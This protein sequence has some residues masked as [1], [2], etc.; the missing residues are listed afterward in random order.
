MSTVADRLHDELHDIWRAPP[1]IGQLSAVNHTAVGTRYI[2]TG[3]V[4]FAVAGLLAMVMRAQLAWAERASVDYATYNELFTMHGTTMMF[5]FA[6]PMV[7]GLAVYL[8]PKM[9]GARDL[10]FPRL[11]AFTYWCYAFGGLLLYSSFVFDAVPDGGWFM[12]VPLNSKPYAPGINADFWLLGIT[13]VEISAV[14]AAI[15]LIVAILKTRAPGMSIDRMPILAWVMLVTAFMI[16][17]GFPPLILGGI[18]LEIERAF[19]IPFYDPA[20][21]GDPL[22][23]QHFFWIFGHPEVYIIFL[24]ATGIVSMVLPT[25]ARAP[26]AGYTWIVLAVI[27]TGFI[28]FGLWVHHMFAVGIPLLALSFFSAASMAV[29][30]PSGIQVFAWITTLWRGR[31]VRSVPLLYI[32]GFL[33]IFVLGGLTGVMVALVPFDW[34]VHD[35]HFVVAHFHY[36]LIGGVVFPLLA[37]IYYWLPL[38]SGRKMLPVL[39]RWA[40]WLLFIGFNVTFLP[41]HLTGLIGMPRRVYTYP[42][43]LGWEHLNALDRRRLHPHRRLRGLPD[44]RDP[45]PAPRRAHGHESLEC[46]EPRVEPA[47]ARADLHLREPPRVASRDPLWDEPRLPEQLERGKGLLAETRA[48]SAIRSGPACSMPR[49]SAC[50]TSR[51]RAGSRSVPRPRSASSSSVRWRSSTPSPS[52]GRGSRSRRS[53]TGCGTRI[54]SRPARWTWATACDCPPADRRASPRPGGRSSPLSSPTRRS[55]SRS[56]SPTSFS[57][58]F[59]PNGRRPA[60]RRSR[61]HC[62]SSLSVCSSRAAPRSRGA[63]ATRGPA[64][65]APACRWRSGSPRASSSSRSPPCARG[66]R[67]RA[68]TSTR[69]WSTRT[70]S[71]SRCTWRRRS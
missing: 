45:A 10:P 13:F 44:R 18:L 55:S 46:R 52:P 33:F 68:R 17:F 12:Y 26:I 23:W 43:G 19:G 49:P 22:L 15:E 21:G 39:G 57:G 34:Q 27:G 56:S 42:A 29:A 14:L 28:S 5:L 48:G 35:T 58:R 37:G 62:R 1:G 53:C 16:V 61:R 41:M 40:F 20:R 59:R 66:R 60:R 63:R 30:I 25:F 4:F 7:E 36:V 67:A 51:A 65:S 32:L 6:V 54:A 64:G 47:H 70:S 9:I 24:P 8:L 31:P 11:G 71:S 2:A 38:H 50:C 69:R 3:F